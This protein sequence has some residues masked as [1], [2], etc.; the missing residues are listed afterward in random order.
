MIDLT[1][2]KFNLSWFLDVLSPFDEVNL[3]NNQNLEIL[4]LNLNLN[5]FISSLLQAKYFYNE[6]TIDKIIEP[7]YDNSLIDSLTFDFTNNE[8][9]DVYNLIES[10]K[11]FFDKNKKTFTDLN[12]NKAYILIIIYFVIKYMIAHEYINLPLLT[13][14]KFLFRYKKHSSND[15]RYIDIIKKILGKDYVN[16]IINN[17]TIQ[18]V[19]FD[20]D[21]L[22]KEYFKYTKVLGYKINP[23]NSKFTAK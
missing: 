11:V 6:K 17:D 22:K 21:K 19:T 23:Y 2:N 16:F 18:L 20:P 15:K 9:K 14:F 3:F 10:F 12:N 7:P 1:N 13:L 8:N 4:I 5:F